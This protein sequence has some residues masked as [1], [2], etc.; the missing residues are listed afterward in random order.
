VALAD[1]LQVFVDA[2]LITRLPTRWQLLQ[3]EIEMTPYVIST[4]ATAEEGYRDHLASHP[5]VRQLMIF[6][7]VGRDHLRTGSALGAKLE[8][9]CAHLVLTYHRGMPVFDL[10]II[11]THRGGLERLRAAIEE[12]L[13]ETTALGR[14]RR[15]IATTLL[16]DP[17]AYL[18]QFL[19]DR[20]WIARAARF[21]YPPPAAEGSK[22]PPEFFSLITLAAYCE[23]SFPASPRDLSAGHY[24][25]HLLRLA[26][27]RARRPLD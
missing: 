9:I 1:R 25:R 11:Q 15:R 5:V 13:G 16:R 14:R 8:S 17:V 26:S 6:A 2:G 4:D 19:G 3:G 27:R 24:P 10:Q 18:E 21:D 12:T 20:G 23:A 7:H 22:F